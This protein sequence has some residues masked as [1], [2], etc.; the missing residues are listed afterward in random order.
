MDKWKRLRYEYVMQPY[1]HTWFALK[2][3]A[4]A[5]I[6]PEYLDYLEEYFE[7]AKRFRSF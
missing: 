2:K 4:K 3:D 6:K 5:A 7:N 1:S